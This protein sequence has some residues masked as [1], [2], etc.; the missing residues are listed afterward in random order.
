LQHNVACLR[1]LVPKFDVVS[2]TD[3]RNLVLQT[4][5]FSQSF[6]EQQSSLAVQLD[7]ACQSEADSLE[8]HRL[9][10]RRRSGRNRKG[11]LL[12]ILLRIQAK[13]SVGAEDEVEIAA[14]A[15]I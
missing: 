6:I 10:R 3:Q 2:H 9:V 12:E 11:D 4:G 5:P 13:Y 1:H 7:F 8:G 14:V 15:S